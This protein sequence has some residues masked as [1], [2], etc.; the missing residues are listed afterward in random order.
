MAII[1]SRKKKDLTLLTIPCQL[2]SI[3]RLTTL[4]EGVV[5]LPRRNRLDTR[6][7]RLAGHR[8]RY[9]PGPSG[10]IEEVCR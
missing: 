6:L 8:H 4:H 5:P 7:Q 3:G 9:Q 1:E 2:L 10:A